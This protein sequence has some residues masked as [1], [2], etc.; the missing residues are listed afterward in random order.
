MKFLQKRRQK[1]EIC[2]SMLIQDSLD[3]T[4]L[5][6]AKKIILFLT[7]GNIKINGGVM[8][9]F[10]LC[11]ASRNVMDDFFCCLSTFPKGPTYVINDKFYNN[12]KI[13]RFSQIINNA[14]SVQEMILHIPE[15][16]ADDFYADLTKKDIKFLKSIP[17]LQIN[18]LNQNIELMPEPEK[19]QDL[20]KLTNNVT[21]TMAHDRYATQ[22]ICNH[23]NIP[24]HL[25]STH[26]DFSKYK[27]INFEKKENIIVLSPDD[28][29]HKSQITETI[30]QNFPNWEIITVQNMTFN[31]YMDLITRAYFVITF[32]EGFDGYFNNPVCVDSIGISVYND[33]FFPD[34]TWKKLENVYSSYDEMMTNICDDLK[35]FRS[36]KKLYYGI[37]QEQSKKL[38][39]IY[40]KQ[41]YLSNI[42]RFYNKEY[43]FIPKIN[44]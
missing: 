42:K 35:R 15:Y 29:E 30:K 3:L 28:E 34:N 37:I 12:E 32:G 6:K 2:A 31:Q 26:L 24:T 11:S 40:S 4:P 21:Q 19:I 8:S 14:K 36:N 1:A 39:L 25:F 13:F 33:E 5:Q 23:W 18:I 10:S 41:K 27:S 17:H 7:P 9:I 16:Y 22:E 38:N 20:Y 43:D 44:K